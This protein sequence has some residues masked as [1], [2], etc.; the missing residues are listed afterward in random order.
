MTDA[1]Q[2][3]FAHPEATTQ[4]LGFVLFADVAPSLDALAAPLEGELGASVDRAQVPLGEA[5]PEAS[6]LVVST[7]GVTVLVSPADEP[8]PDGAALRSCHPVWWSDPEPA[9]SHRAAVVVTT[10]RPPEV[11]ADLDALLPEAIA[12]STVATLLAELPGAVGV[13]YP[14]GGITFPAAAYAELVREHLD[15]GQLPTDVWVSAWLAREDDG[16]IG[17]C[18]LGLA[19]FGHAELLVEH[20]GHEASEVYGLLTGLAGQLVATGSGLMPGA[21]VGPSETEQYEV[22]ARDGGQAGP[23]L[24]IDY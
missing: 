6:A 12:F 14:N 17:G 13:F 10:V 2:P 7:Q 3:A 11:P 24:Q 18:T 20:S 22:S 16:T 19:S 15:A 4:F 5:E 1:A 21:T 23:M 9:A 8:V